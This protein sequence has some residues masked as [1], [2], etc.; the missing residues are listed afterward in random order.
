MNSKF[1]LSDSV[2]N[3][4]NKLVWWAFSKRKYINTYFVSCLHSFL[5][6]MNETI[7]SNALFLFSYVCDWM[8]RFATIFFLFC[9]ILFYFICYS[10]C[11]ILDVCKIPSKGS[12]NK[13]ISS[14]V[15]YFWNWPWTFVCSLPILFYSDVFEAKA[16]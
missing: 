5:L 6:R 12:K 13:V 10:I 14:E 3:S 1:C 2:I 7:S 9:F 8:H 4:P 15:V 16:A 11:E